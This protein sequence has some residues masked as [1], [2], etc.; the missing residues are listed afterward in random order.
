MNMEM[1][2]QGRSMRNVFG[3]NTIVIVVYIRNEIFK[4]ATE[5]LQMKERI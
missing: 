2:K 4:G 3:S 5:I 1:D